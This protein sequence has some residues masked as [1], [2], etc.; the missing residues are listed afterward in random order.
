MTQNN[1]Q[2]I[3][4]KVEI[5]GSHLQMGQQIGEACKEQVKHSVENARVLLDTAYDSLQ[6]TWDMAKIQASK[7]IPFAEE[8]YPQFVDELRGIAAGSGVSFGDIC[9]V[10]VMEAVTV[11]AL[12]LTK[13]T[14]LAINQERSL[15]GHVMLAHNEDWVPEDEDDVF[16]VEAYPDN[17]PAFMAMTYGALLPNIGFNE[18]GIAQCIDSVYPSDCRIGVPRLI[19][20]RAV[21]SAH[22]LDEA[23]RAILV[24][25]RAA[26]YNHLLAHESG[27]LYNVEVSAHYFALMSSENG[28]LVHTNHYTDS[29]MRKVEHE[30]DELIS[31]RVR[32]FRAQRL[33]RQTQMHTRDSL[34][35]V[36]RDHVNHPDSI[37][38][39]ATIGDPLDR[40]KTV[41]S[42]VMDLSERCMYAAWGSPCESEY[43]L[44]R[45]G[46]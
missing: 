26:G 31:T 13:C 36:L 10:N 19:Y 9:V 42:L 37:C 44:F 35:R 41:C 33:M 32:Y 3:L 28:T 4:K 46:F 14:S 6:L 16:L 30:P 18:H 34:T 22:T 8:R 21:L 11:D 5:R 43:H 45:P 1:G 40:E 2:K 15:D 7:Y 24:P 27:E 39:H 38:N 20:S 29:E 12:H 17:E 25:Q 23:L